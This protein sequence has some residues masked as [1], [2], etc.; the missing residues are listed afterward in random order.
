MKILITPDS[1]K[2]SANAAVVASALAK[3]IRSVIKDKIEITELPLGDG[4]EGTAD[5]LAKALGGFKAQKTKCL[6]AN[7][8]PIDAAWFFN[9]KTGTAILDMAAASGITHIAT[10]EFNILGANTFGTGQLIKEAMALGAQ[11]IIIGLGGSATN[12]AGIGLASA[13]GYQFLDASKNEV[14]P[15]PLNFKEIKRIVSP[16]VDWPN[17]TGIYDVDIKLLGSHGAVARYA[18]QKGANHQEKKYLEQGLHHL[19]KVLN[20]DKETEKGAGAAGGLGYGLSTFLNA[21]LK[22]GFQFVAETLELEKKIIEADFVI[23]GEGKVDFQTL[24]GKLVKGVAALAKKHNKPLIIVAGQIHNMLALQEQLIVLD[25]VN[26]SEMANSIEKSILQC[27]LW[28]QQAGE[29][30]ARKHFSQ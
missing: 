20:S 21:Q 12:D 13:L 18:A 26:L 11:E 24:D 23:T 10:S 1:F 4:G 8:K 16:E 2:G 30:L 27:E 14:L 5:A 28:L 29:K 9:V 25:W 19:V 7:R 15:I 3:G 6:N 22:P 17:F